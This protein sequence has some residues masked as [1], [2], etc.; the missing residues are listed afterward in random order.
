MKKLDLAYKVSIISIIVNIILFAFKLIAGIIGNSKAMIS[1]AIHSASDIISTIVVIIG[2]FISR[3]QSDEKHPYG[4]EKFECIAAIVLSAMLFGVSIG[5]CINGVESLIYS[6]YNKISSPSLIA[7]LAAII[8][9]I[10]KEWMYRFTVSASKKEDSPALLADAWHHRS[11]ALSSIGAL[12]GI[13]FSM[14]GYKIFDPIAS[15]IIGIFIIK[16]AW[17][18][19]MDSINKMVD[20]SASEDIIKKIINIIESEKEVKN[21]DSVKTRL[22]GSKLYVDIEIAVKGS[23][24]VNKSHEIAERIHDNVEE[25]IKNCKHC[26]VH[27]NPYNV[28]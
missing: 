24:T 6:D 3:K 10:T 19:L 17:D 9:I 22:F 21:I 18:I 27:V 23:L 2:I 5:I 20:T 25:N 1:D 14:L 13:G 28:K 15:L 26:M 11:D 7:L 16:A 12:I 8:S 4:H